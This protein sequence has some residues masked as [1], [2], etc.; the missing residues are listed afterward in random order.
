MPF[1]DAAAHQLHQGGLHGA[2][3]VCVIDHRVL[4]AARRA[5]CAR[6]MGIGGYM[7]G[8]R[9]AG[10]FRHTPDR[11]VGG[12]EVRPIRR[13]GAGDAA[14]LEAHADDPLKLSGAGG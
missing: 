1:S 13:R 2:R 11:L 4:P 6:E 8:E 14:T 5:V 10:L 3:R 12:V 9:K 7:H